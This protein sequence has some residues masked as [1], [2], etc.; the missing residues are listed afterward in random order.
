MEL[1]LI[2]LCVIFIFG[3]LFL[4]FYF[5]KQLPKKDDSLLAFQEQVKEIR[6]SIDRRTSDT[7]KIIS[8]ITGKIARL[9]ETNKQVVNFASQLYD[10]QNILSNP[11]QRGVVGEYFLETVLS[12]VLPPNSYQMQYYFKNGEAVDAVIFVKDKIIPIDSKFSLE[13]YQR[14]VKAV[15]PQEKKSLEER[16]RKDLKNRIEE[17]S[18]YIRPAEKTMDFVFMFIPSEALFYDLLINRVGSVESEDLVSYAVREKRVIIVSPTSFLAYLQT[19]LQGLKA[20]EIEKSAMEIKK[21]IEKLAVHLLN[22]D[23]YLKKLG[24]HL[25]TTVNFYEKAGNEFKK[26]DKGIYKITGSHCLPESE[27]E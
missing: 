23:T 24:E 17:T 15:S 26:I 18:K 7:L 12:N 10:L 13:N 5:K 8:D 16:L 19:V 6:E 27:Q 11:K 22:F 25:K 20:L 21:R 4:F 2:I 3:F 9:D 1:L 14:L